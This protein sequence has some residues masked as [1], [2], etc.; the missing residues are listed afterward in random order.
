MGE[1]TSVHQTDGP[2]FDAFYSKANR[3]QKNFKGDMAT[4]Y[5][6]L[7]Q[8][9]EAS[10]TSHEITATCKNDES[11]CLIRK[12]S[13][14]GQQ[15]FAAYMQ[16]N[17]KTMNFCD[18]FFDTAVVKPTKSYIDEFKNKKE[19]VDCQTLT[20]FRNTRAGIIIHELTHTSFGMNGRAKSQDYAYNV[21]KCLQLAEGTYDRST[22]GSSVQLFNHATKQP[23]VTAKAKKPLCPSKDDPTK[24]GICSPTHS[25]DNADNII[26][27][28]VGVY[29]SHLAGRQIE[30][31]PKKTANPS[32]PKVETLQGRAANKPGTCPPRPTLPDM[33]ELPSDFVIRDRAHS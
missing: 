13:W 18:I 2:Y 29:Y 12:D 22:M 15:A 33:F 7:E 4:V 3:D 31:V 32:S 8:L 10:F 16:A 30:I 26:L 6:R 14:D 21:E 1:Y 19:D 28:S 24:E 17:E 25:W 11:K 23:I 27:V 20:D 9:A 5:K